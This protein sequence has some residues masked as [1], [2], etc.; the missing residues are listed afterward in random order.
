MWL[1]TKTG[2]VSVVQKPSDREAGTLTVRSRDYESLDCL[3]EDIYRLYDYEIGETEIMENAATDYRYRMVITREE[4]KRYMVGMIDGITYD[5]FKNEITESRP[6][7]GRWS[8]P[9]MRIWA[10]TLDFGDDMEAGGRE[11]GVGGYSRGAVH[12]EYSET[13]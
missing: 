8:S 5:N 9:L 3:R 6:D 7:G 1:F 4:L 13:T 2:F 10:A 11:Y 12:G